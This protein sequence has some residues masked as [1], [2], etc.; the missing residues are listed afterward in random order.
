MS[1]IALVCLLVGFIRGNFC[2]RLFSLYV[3]LNSQWTLGSIQSFTW[4]NLSLSLSHTHI[5]LHHP[6]RQLIHFF[7]F[8]TITYFNVLRFH[9]L[10]F[11]PSRSH[12][13]PY[14]KGAVSGTLAYHY[15]TLARPTTIGTFPRN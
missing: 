3:A 13:Y 12:T 6:S 8:V 4:G 5:Q 7:L 10:I 11:Y 1:S 15:F 2:V 14:Y 9:S